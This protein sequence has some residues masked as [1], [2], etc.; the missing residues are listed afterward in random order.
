MIELKDYTLEIYVTDKRTKK[1]ERLYGKY[2]Y[3]NKH[4]QWMQEEMRDLAAGL[5]PS[6]KY[7]MELHETYV[8]RTNLMTGKE[9]KERYDVPWTCS[10]AS[11]TYWSS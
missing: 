2:E 1:G 10:A 4:S 8:T 5:Y 6:P 9:F 7:R 11:E 3:P